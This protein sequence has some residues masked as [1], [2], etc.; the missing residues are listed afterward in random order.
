MYAVSVE[1]CD[2]N[3]ILMRQRLGGVNGEWVNYGST[4]AGCGDIAWFMRNCA[5]GLDLAELSRQA[6]HIPAGCEGLLF[7]PYLNGERAPLWNNA[8]AGGFAGLRSHHRTAHMFR[9]VLEGVA[10]GK[11][12]ILSYLPEA[13]SH[14]KLSG[15]STVNRLWNQIRCDIIGKECAVI[16]EKE[17]ALIGVLRSLMENNDDHQ[18]A[19]RLKESLH[20]TI[21]QPQQETQVVYQEQFMRFKDMQAQLLASPVNEEEL[22]CLSK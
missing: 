3:T 10:F 11:R 16:E 7:M 18:I 20:A 15:G 14:C 1:L 13:A 19:Q 22:V 5:S 17:I 9:A 6:M 4:N 8:I 21:L 12:D 2:E